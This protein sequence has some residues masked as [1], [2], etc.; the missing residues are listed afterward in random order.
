[1]GQFIFMGM[2]L[3]MVMS[4]VGIPVLI[5][6]RDNVAAHYFVTASLILVGSNSILLLLFVPKVLAL[7]ER[8]RNPRPSESRVSMSGDHSFY[9]VTIENGALVQ[10]A[11]EEENR[12][13]RKENR[14]LSRLLTKK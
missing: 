1:M 12:E 11:L 3:N 6:T 7:W 9:G 10:A 8:M 4:L 5:M 2:T 13:L 14:E